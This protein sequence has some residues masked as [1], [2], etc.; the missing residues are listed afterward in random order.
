MANS[1]FEQKGGYLLISYQTLRRTIGYIGVFLPVFLIL[2][3]ILV[4]DCRGIQSSI[5][6]YYHTVM[7]DGLVGIICS[8]SFFLFCYT[9]YDTRDLVT[10]RMAGVFA[11]LVALFP[12]DFDGPVQEGCNFVR[13]LDN[14][15]IP[16]VHLTFAALFF[17]TLAYMCIVLFTES[18]KLKQDLEKPKKNRNRI[19]RTCGYT[20]LACIALITVYFIWF[21]GDRYPG[22]DKLRPIFWLES[23]ALFA[24]GIAWLTKGET[25]FPDDPKG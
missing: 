13:E 1:L 9:G 16:Y 12:T 3:A 25:I 11:L 8:I 15:L 24:F 20:M 22:L 5:S 10:T 19:Y 21:D 7:R 18:D 4:G 2:G 17:T 6:T 14:P 23:I